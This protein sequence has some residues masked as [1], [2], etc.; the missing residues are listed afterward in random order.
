MQKNTN[1]ISILYLQSKLV[2][3]VSKMATTRGLQ[4]ERKIGK[5]V[6]NLTVNLQRVTQI[7]MMKVI[8]VD[9]MTGGLEI[10]HALCSSGVLTSKI[11]ISSPLSIFCFR[12]SALIC[13]EL[14]LSLSFA[15]YS[16]TY[17][18]YKK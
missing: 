11:K 12:L 7:H 18:N 5:T 10:F 4:H 9:M 14:P 6:M 17:E 1:C 15:I 3:Q 13:S 8:N 2:K 16:R